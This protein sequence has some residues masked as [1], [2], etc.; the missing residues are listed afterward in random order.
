MSSID[1]IKIFLQDVV[2]DVQKLLGIM[3][4]GND[5]EGSIYLD[6][7]VLACAL[8]AYSQCENFTRRKLLK[9]T[10]KDKYDELHDEICLKNTPIAS[11]QAIKFRYPNLTPPSFYTLQVNVDYYLDRD[12]VYLATVKMVDNILASATDACW[13]RVSPISLEI[14]YTGG[15]ANA[16]SDSALF[17][18][19]VSQ[20]VAN[21]HRKETLGLAQVRGSGGSDVQQIASSDSVVTSAKDAWNCLVYYGS[22]ESL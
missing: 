9:G 22:G 19:L 20:T 3:P 11:V 2:L 10:Y 4:P 15:F 13:F 1:S 5:E 14:D 7:K 8:S 6:E 17:T 18:G 21:F 16:S 12:T